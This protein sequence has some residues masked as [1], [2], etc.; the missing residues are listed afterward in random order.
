MRDLGWFRIP[1]PSCLTCAFACLYVACCQSRIY[2]HTGNHL[3]LRKKG[4]YKLSRPFESKCCTCYCSVLCRDVWRKCIQA[5]YVWITLPLACCIC[6]FTLPGDPWNCELSDHHSPKEYLE[7]LEST[8]EEL[9]CWY[10]SDMFP[11]SHCTNCKK[12]FKR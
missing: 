4:R 6:W 2:H 1:D 8:R 3:K 5:C 10:L 7:R 11:R 9:E 12:F